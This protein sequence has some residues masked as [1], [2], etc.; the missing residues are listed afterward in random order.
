MRRVSA[1]KVVFVW[2][3]GSSETIHERR[4]RLLID[5]SLRLFRLPFLFIRPFSGNVAKVLGIRIMGRAFNRP[6][7]TFHKEREALFVV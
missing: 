6:R 7:S 3:L 2:S 5:R 1:R 4:K